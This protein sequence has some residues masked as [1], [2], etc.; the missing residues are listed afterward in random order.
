M[1]GHIHIN[2]GLPARQRGAALILVAIGMLAILAMAGLALDGCHAPQQVA[3]AEHG[4]CRG[5]QR[6]QGAGSVREPTSRG[7]RLS[8]WT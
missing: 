3:P 2:G 5:T 4:R 6:G 8:T 1:N 7:R